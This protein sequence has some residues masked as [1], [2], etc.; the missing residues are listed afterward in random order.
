MGVKPNEVTKASGVES[1]TQTRGEHVVD[2]T[3]E[4]PTIAQMREDRTPRQ[5]MHLWPLHTRTHGTDDMS[6]RVEY[7]AIDETLVISEAS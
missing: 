3:R 7:G 2:M 6:L 4:H 5:P 1:G